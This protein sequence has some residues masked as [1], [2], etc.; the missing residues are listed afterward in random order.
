MS[1]AVLRFP[2]NAWAE[3]EALPEP[4]R[5]AVHRTAFHLLAEPVP[6]LADPFPELD[7]L[8]GACRL[9]LPDDGVTLG[10]RRG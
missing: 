2:E 5:G 9:Y 6:T 1:D 7:P 4:L 8:P 3:V 10:H